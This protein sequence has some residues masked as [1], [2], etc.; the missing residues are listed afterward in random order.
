MNV[1]YSA[2][3]VKINCKP[4]TKA[5]DL[6]TTM[7]SGNKGGVPSQPFIKYKNGSEKESVYLLFHGYQSVYVQ[8]K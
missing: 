6:L 7:R 4:A 1:A 5:K 3:Y 8:Q 2:E